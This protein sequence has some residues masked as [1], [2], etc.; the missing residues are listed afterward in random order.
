MRSSDSQN[1]G[2][3]HPMTFVLGCLL[4]LA[5]NAL[6]FGGSRWSYYFGAGALAGIGVMWLNQ[7]GDLHHIR[8]FSDG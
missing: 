1:T 6:W 4:Y 3:L 5:A 2:I 7:K 8:V